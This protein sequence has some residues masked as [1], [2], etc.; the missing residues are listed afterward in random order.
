MKRS[1]RTAQLL[2]ATLTSLT[3]V[4]FS[5]VTLAASVGDAPDAIQVEAAVTRNAPAQDELE[6]SGANS[7]VTLLVQPPVGGTLRLTYIPDDGWRFDDHDSSLKST[8]A[9]VTPAAAS[10]K[11]EDT[12]AKRPIT[13]FIDGPTGYTYVWTRDQG[14]KFVGRITDHIK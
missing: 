11:K 3:L 13:V 12:I 1:S 2:L 7:P 6:T 8:E 5:Q 4:T 9:R 10:Q 14:W